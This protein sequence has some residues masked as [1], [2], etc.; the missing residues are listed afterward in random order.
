MR[1]LILKLGLFNCLYVT[2]FIL[3]SGIMFT[4]N[5][6]AANIVINRGVNAYMAFYWLSP[7]FFALVGENLML[8]I[9]GILSCVGGAVV[10][11][12][13]EGGSALSLVKAICRLVLLNLIALILSLLLLLC[14]E[15]IIVSFRGNI[16][17]SIVYHSSEIFLA[18]M[19]FLIFW[20]LIGL[21][22][23]ITFNSVVLSLAIG[24]CIQL[25]EVFVIY[26]Y[27]PQI[28]I[29]LPTALSRNLV[30]S[31]FPFWIPGSWANVEGAVI[32]A[33]SSML[34]N[35]YYQNVA[36]WKYWVPIML[37]YYVAIVFILPTVRIILGQH[38]KHY[39][40]N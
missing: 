13:K 2:T 9:S 12:N 18:M 34:V 20:S 33:N 3:L 8:L 21:G 7:R 14:M 24:I 23:R 19:I 39:D 25:T 36:L 28:E 40:N 32:F 27:V 26:R 6:H 29:Y 38:T 17:I 15:L 35:K 10:P 37:V 5:M 11:I 1:K 31:Q 16:D 4:V 22:L 30:V